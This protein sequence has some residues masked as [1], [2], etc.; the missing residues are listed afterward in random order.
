MGSF[1]LVAFA[2]A[3]NAKAPI[4]VF[5][6]ELEFFDIVSNSGG[7]NANFSRNAPGSSFFG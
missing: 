7:V 2:G 5:P 1:F 4:Y 6:F 3:E